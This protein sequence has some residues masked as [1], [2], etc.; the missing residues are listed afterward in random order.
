MR[1]VTRSSL[2]RARRAS[3]RGEQRK[4]RVFFGTFMMEIEEQ[5]VTLLCQTVCGRGHNFRGNKTALILL[6]GCI[7]VFC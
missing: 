2:K 1:S 6:L 7:I 4:L 5:W 3:P